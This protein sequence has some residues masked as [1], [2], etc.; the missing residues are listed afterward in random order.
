M[1]VPLQ[2]TVGGL[3]SGAFFATQYLVSHSSKVSGAAVFAGGPWWCA[4]NNADLALTLC[5]DP[6]LLPP[7]DGGLLADAARAAAD[8]GLVDDTSNLADAKIFVYSGRLDSVVVREVVDATVAFYNHFVSPSSGGNVTSEFDVPSEH[9]FPTP[10]Y[11]QE[12]DKLGDPYINDC[13]Y[14]GAGRGLTALYGPLQP[15]VSP[16]TANLLQFDQTLFGTGASLNTVGYV[17]VPTA[18]QKNAVCA[19][20]VNFHG[21][22]QT[23]DDIGMQYVEDTGLNGWAEANNIVVVYPQV[24]RSGLIP[25]NPEG[26]WDWWGYDDLNYANKEGTQ[27][28]FV[29]RIVSHIMNTGA[30]KGAAAS[31]VV[32]SQ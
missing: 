29:D 23:L 27:I 14:D 26:C 20:H 10:S 2:L 5:M 15:S 19:L 13:S 17:Y 21:C 31:P 6:G 3:S 16:V 28:A 12:C 25:Y 24:I 18:C 22:K 9:C 11:G 8:G 4:Q 30:A 32:A 7:P 1:P